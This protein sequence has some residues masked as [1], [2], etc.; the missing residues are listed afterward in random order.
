MLKFWIHKQ[1]SKIK[2]WWSEPPSSKCIFVHQ[3]TATCFRHIK[4][5]FGL[6]DLHSRKQLRPA[7]SVFPIFRTYRQP[8]PVAKLYSSWLRLQLSRFAVPNAHPSRKPPQWVPNGCYWLWGQGWWPRPHPKRTAFHT[9]S[10]E[11]NHAKS[12]NLTGITNCLNLKYVQTRGA[13][14]STVYQY[15]CTVGHTVRNA[16]RLSSLRSKLGRHITQLALLQGKGRLHH[17]HGHAWL[18]HLNEGIKA[19]SSEHYIYIYIYIKLR[20]NRMQ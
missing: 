11:W 2:T 13:S 4:R 8:F 5:H 18:N 19:P 16:P 17:R 3:S 15:N 1:P 14:S 12:K 20:F 7:R 9:K 10:G 6:W